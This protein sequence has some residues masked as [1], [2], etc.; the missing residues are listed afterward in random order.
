MGKQTGLGDNFYIA[1]YDVSGD[2]QSLGN[3]SC[4]QGA[5]D[6]T[7]IDKSAH[8]RAGGARDGLVE[9]TTF[10]NDADDQEHEALSSLPRTNVDLMYCRGTTLGNAAA[11]LRGKQIDYALNRGD[12]GSLT[13]GVQAQANAYGLEWGR[14]L[15]AGKRTDTTATNGAT[16][17]QTTAST[18]FGWQAYLQAFALTGTSCTVT[19]EDS[20]NGS[21]WATL[22]GAGF[23]AFTGRGV[24]RKQASSSTAT[25][26]RYVRA[27]T[28]GTFSS[29]T[30][31]LVFIRNETAV[32]F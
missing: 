13:F 4:P 27:V 25:V 14:L 17:D 21:G 16:L 19:I 20:A 11:C 5:L 9:F 23:T 29:A 22:S 6:L 15:T 3:V 2:V 28:T 32:T 1:G 8:E 12:D 30:F 7:G 24:E 10:F 18:S 31:A 26:R